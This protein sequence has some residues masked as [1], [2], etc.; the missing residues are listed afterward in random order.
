MSGLPQFQHQLA[1]AGQLLQL[2]TALAE[3]KSFLHRVA[4][5]P[6]Q[7]LP[8]A[9]IGVDLQGVPLAIER[10]QDPCG[11]AQQKQIVLLGPAVACQIVDLPIDQVLALHPADRIAVLARVSLSQI[12]RA[13]FL[14]LLEGFAL[15]TQ[16]P[17]QIPRFED[18]VGLPGGHQVLLHLPGQD[19]FPAGDHRLLPGA[20][21]NQG[22]LV[23]Q[24]PQAVLVGQLFG[25]Q[26]DHVVLGA[27][28]FQFHV[29]R[30]SAVGVALGRFARLGL[31]RGP[32]AKLHPVDRLARDEPALCFREAAMPSAAVRTDHPVAGGQIRPIGK[33][34]RH[35]GVGGVVGPTHLVNLVAARI[36][37]ERE[38]ADLADHLGSAQVEAEHGRLLSAEHGP[39]VPPRSP[40][41]PSVTS[42]ARAAVPF[43]AST[44]TPGRAN[45][46]APTRVRIR[47]SHLAKS[48]S[49]L[50]Q[51][52]VCR[53]TSA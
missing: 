51:A 43:S 11:A 49:E 50:F 25:G 47:S 6:R 9:P 30:L 19:R 53:A 24:V 46:L 29:R 15:G 45:R 32:H 37:V 33:G 31:V 41:L 4:P 36:A 1:G 52:V 34:G 35:A 44:R 26:R 48:S 40:A 5:P 3:F 39:S 20:L 28:H 38:R 12:D 10:T 27:D 22:R 23:G 16:R 13:G 42:W 21:D 8:A 7:P 17:E 18:H 14:Q 2:R